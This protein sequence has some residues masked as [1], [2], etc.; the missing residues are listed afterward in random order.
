MMNNFLFKPYAA[1]PDGVSAKGVAQRPATYELA[2]S[3]F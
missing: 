1:D 3:H 2:T